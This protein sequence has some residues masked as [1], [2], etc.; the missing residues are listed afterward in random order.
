MGHHQVQ[1]NEIRFEIGVQRHDLARVRR[2]ADVVPSGVAQNPLEQP[3]VRRLVVDNENPTVHQF[4]IS[5]GLGA[6]ER[7]IDQ[8]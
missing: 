7:G 1:Q 4:V 8:R 6:S 5:L 2:R 3:H